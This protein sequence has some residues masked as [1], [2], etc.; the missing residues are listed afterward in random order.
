MT[1]LWTR[2]ALTDVAAVLAEI[3]A[4]DPAAASRFNDRL[5]ELIET[6]LVTQPRMGRPGRV[7][8]TRELIVHPRY[9]LA[10]RVRSEVLELLAFRH[11]VRL[12]PDRF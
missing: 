7:T 6:T 5:L 2:R 4:E 12:W 8:D 1:I 11:S 9:I 10:Y 3:A